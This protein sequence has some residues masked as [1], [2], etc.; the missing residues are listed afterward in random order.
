MTDTDIHAQA[1]V[2]SEPEQVVQEDDET[3]LNDIWTLY[4]HDP[5]NEDW[6]YNSYHKLIDVTSVHEFWQMHSITNEKIHCGMFF[7][8]RE[9]VFPCWDDENNKNGGCLSIKVLKQDMAEFWEGLCVR[10]LGE[11]LLKPDHRQ[12]WNYV[13]GVS[14]SPKKYFCIIKIWVKSAE[15]SHVEMFDIPPKH[16]GEILYRSNQENIDNDHM[17]HVVPGQEVM[18]GGNGK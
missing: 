13:N 14:T 6:T 2:V 8:M 5:Y 7:L 11:T 16:H 4:F 9:Y 17:K 1:V 15:L 10:L 3:P 18:G 12:Y